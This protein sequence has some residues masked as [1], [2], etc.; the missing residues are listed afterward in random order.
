MKSLY[1]IHMT[2]LT[3]IKNGITSVLNTELLIFGDHN[4]QNLNAARLVCNEIGIS[5]SNFLDKIATFKGASNRLELLKKSKN[6][7]IYKDFAHSPSKLKATIK[8]MRQQFKNRNLVACM[9]L[10]TFSSLNEKFLKQY[11]DSM[12]DADTAIIYFNPDAI[13]HKKL[14]AITKKQVHNAFNRDDLM[15]FTSSKEL[16][17]HLKHQNWKNKNLL[18]MSSG[19]FNGINLQ[20]IV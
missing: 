20:K 16:E 7:S 2:I 9:E 14:N 1:T 3:K 15:V 13:A 8:A 12:S 18:M 17:K 10:H 4:L 11:K 6:S 5:N 19:N